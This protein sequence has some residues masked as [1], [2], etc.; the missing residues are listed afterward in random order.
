LV[1]WGAGEQAKGDSGGSAFQVGQKKSKLAAQLEP[2]AAAKS[3]KDIFGHP[4]GLTTLAGTELW[5]RISFHGMV[6]L[7]TLYMADQ[8]LLPG[9]IEKIVGFKAYRHVLEWITGPLSV[10]ALATQTFGLYVA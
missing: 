3:G 4:R 8:L 7:L 2:P 5:E 6:A 1:A 9:H 10:E